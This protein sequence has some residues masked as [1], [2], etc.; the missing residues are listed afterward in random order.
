MTD[1][2]IIANIKGAY[3]VVVLV[4]QSS[5]EMF[6]FASKEK[7]QFSYFMGTSVAIC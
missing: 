4:I 6:E 3:N 7:I 5:G 1:G 2:N